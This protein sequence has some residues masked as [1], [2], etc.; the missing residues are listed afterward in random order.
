M[1]EHP[2]LTSGSSASQSPPDIIATV[3]IENAEP[4]SLHS[5]SV[6]ITSPSL[7]HPTLHL[8][9]ILGHTVIGHAAEGLGLEL[10][11]PAAGGLA[12]E[13]R[14]PQG[15]RVE[16]A[17]AP[18]LEGDR[19]GAE[20]GRA[21]AA[22]TVDGGEGPAQGA[23]PVQPLAATLS[24]QHLSTVLPLPELNRNGDS[25]F[26]TMQF[27]DA[28]LPE[29]AAESPSQ[30]AETLVHSISRSPYSLSSLD[31]RQNDDL[32]F[33][34]TDARPSEPAASPSQLV[35]SLVQS[36]SSG[37]L[38]TPG[39][40]R[41]GY[42][43]STAKQFADVH[44]PGPATESHSQSVETLVQ[45]VRESPL[46]REVH[47]HL[48]PG[49]PQSIGRYECRAVVP[50][51]PTSFTLP[52]LDFP[53][54]PNLPPPGWTVCKHP[55]GAR[56]FFHEKK[57]VFT[58]ADLTDSE[59][60][61]LINNSIRDIYDFLRARS[62][63]FGHNVDLVL[64]DYAEDEG[65]QYYFANHG[66]RSV[67]WLDK[68][69]SD[70][71]PV[72]DEV[73]GMTSTSH[74][75]HELEAQ[76]WL[77]CEY[78]PAAIEVTHEMVDE[79][80]DIVLHA[81]GDLVTSQTST[82][83]YKIDDL[84]NMITLIDGFS[85]NVGKHGQKKFNG[86]S[87]LIG[88]FM[89]VFVRNRVYNFYG[90]PAAR[91]NIGQ[92]VYATRQKR[93]M[94]IKT[95]SPLLFY[96][97]DRHLSNLGK[98]YHDG[99][100][101]SREW[102][103]FIAR[104]TKE[105]SDITLYTTMLL[106]A[107]VGFL[108]IQSVDNNGE[109]HYMR[110]PM[111]ISSY[112]SMLTSIGSI[113]IGLLLTKQ[114]RDRDRAPAS[115]AATFISN[116]THPTLGHETLAVL[117]SLPYAML[118]WSMVSF[119]AAFSFMC[120]VRSS[121]LTRALITVVWIAVAALIMWCV[122]NSFE[123]SDWDW[124]RGLLCWRRSA[125]MD[126]AGDADATNGEN[127]ANEEGQASGARESR[128][129]DWTVYT[130]A[131][132]VP[133]HPSSQ[134]ITEY[135]ITQ[136]SESY[137][138]QSL[139]VQH[140][141]AQHRHPSSAIH[142]LEHLPALPPS[143]NPGS[144]SYLPST[145]TS[146]VDSVPDLMESPPCLNDTHERIFPGTPETIAR[147]SCKTII[148]NEPTRFTIAPLTIS[149]LPTPPPSGWTTCQH[150]EGAKY[151][152]HEEEVCR[153]FTDANLWDAETLK[154]INDN[155]RYV[156]DFLR[157]H[158]VHLDPGIDLVLD[159]YVY[160]DK[161]KGCQYYFVSHHG[162]CVFWMDKGDSS[163][164][165]VTEE[166]KGMTSASHIGHELEAQYWLHC[167]YYPRAFEVTHEI[168]D[169]LRDIVL[170][171]FGDVITSQTST[172]SW[173]TDD[174]KSIITL[175][176]GFDKIM[177]RD[178][179]H[180][181]T[182]TKCMVGRLMHVF[183]RSRVYNF[184]GEPG[185]R[186]NVDQSVHAIVQKRTM[187]IKTL[188]PLLFYAPEYY[189]SSFHGIQTDRL[190][191]PREWSD[192]ITGLNRDWQQFTLLATVVLNANVAFLAIQSVDDDDNNTVHTRSP[193]QISSYLSMMTS[194]GSII[195]GLLLANKIRN[196][197]RSPPS[198]AAQFLFTN[199]TLGLETRAILY[200]LPYAL[201]IW[202]VMSFLAAFLFLCFEKSSLVTRTLV[203]VL[204]IVIAAFVSWCIYAN[205]EGPDWKMNWA[206]WWL[207]DDEPQDGKPK[208]R[209]WAVSWPSITGKAPYNWS[210][211]LPRR[212]LD[213]NTANEHVQPRGAMLESQPQKR[214]WRWLPSTFS[215]RS[216]ESGHEL[217]VV[218]V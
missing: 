110:S 209:R 208:K 52:P 198:I 28:Q 187:L 43:P 180:K 143:P 33:T 214:W 24:A 71:F 206:A 164:F 32:L 126:A 39:I 51:E 200:S 34:D 44:L 160:D 86:S 81:L 59:K 40:G 159:E 197:D 17:V 176:E 102:S 153:V 69:D 135:P 174:L 162:R 18:A 147:Y 134:D 90:E 138:Q 108:A 185:A 117:Y 217:V 177:G 76:Y 158:N 95:L 94:L 191:R 105:W 91:L 26:T 170:H 3:K 88:R 31:L 210:P 79:L 66:D 165:P 119:L 131:S 123:N 60:L 58:D 109:A 50:D 178:S 148:P 192:F 42:L 14:V 157:A 139:S 151:F 73:K 111:Q 175:I 20:R 122:S 103:D 149:V 2:S 183:A 193:M 27:A 7:L 146:V 45:N 113:I 82:V 179:G 204:G 19:G 199:P 49:T 75:R 130:S 114:T 142:S 70:L 163:L 181:I 68:A 213:S 166:L 67:F 125:A 22:Q 9:L 21:S 215:K 65:C 100:T 74:I 53:L 120:F 186:L 4:Y 145:N 30:S 5:L 129:W 140:L 141:P 133:E 156:K 184:H 115:E 150:P 47:P 118:I 8:E 87:S 78:Y 61:Q 23:S 10:P 98:I 169:E 167:E 205:W 201:F 64:S 54:A 13:V 189:L 41:H 216:H 154:F 16:L 83:S 1:S 194:I 132:F 116:R 85:K 161:T 107:N 172:V 15:L 173:K 93:T 96:A 89:N 136:D 106:N 127:S 99:L 212:H 168:V 57:R 29:P 11:A 37:P 218:N 137:L 104:L 128:N 38:P 6:T 55:E 182:G 12:E 155:I 92:S 80:R 188:T 195:I 207:Q 190:I 121:A 62:I 25:S 171:A 152:F 63:Q 196:R 35:A 202:S 84:N 36:I 46:L 97:P 77:H 48:F 211:T 144:A 124:L 112:L 72:T 101:R 56:Y 203:A